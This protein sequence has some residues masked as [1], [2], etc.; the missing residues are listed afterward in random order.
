MMRTYRP[1]CKSSHDTSSDVL[2]VA[3]IQVC[4]IVDTDSWQIVP[5][6]WRS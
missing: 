4:V 2:V 5:L 3:A 6:L 1:S